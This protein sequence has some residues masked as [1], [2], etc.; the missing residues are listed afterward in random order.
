M[1][2][3]NAA[4]ILVTGAAKGIGEA[5][6]SR[7]VALGHRVF[8]GV[9][10]PEDGDALR[11][12]LGDSVRPVLLDVNDG[13]MI[14]AAAAQLQRELGKEGLS[15]LVNNAG[16]AIAGPLEFLPI[17][18]LRRQLEINVVG[19]VA[20]T[21][22][23]L[24]L[25]RQ[26]RGRIVFIGSVSGRSALPFTGAYAASKFALEA[27]ADAWRV[28]LLPW[29]LHVSIV[30]PGVIRTPIW[31]T[32]MATA[33]RIQAEVP[34]EAEQYYGT[35]TAGLRRHA[36]R[37]ERGEQ[38]LPPDAVAQVVEHALFA[39]RP[40]VRYVVGRDARLRLL[41]GTLL[42]TRLRDRVIIRRMK[43]L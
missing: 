12:R 36:Q 17:A 27:I 14:A 8:A 42:P 26:G 35:L 20:V 13:A 24:P 16:I 29:R 1:S 37:A 28:E 21:Q 19:Q 2:R 32:S 34:P 23:L 9:R 10:R 5:C 33:D 18:D 25:L 31:S 7:L 3:T 11:S 6:V 40:R 30:E 22:A 39:A 15:G 43:R 38:G 4:S 41:I